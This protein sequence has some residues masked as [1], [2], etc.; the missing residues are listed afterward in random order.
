MWCWESK[1]GSHDAWKNA[2]M[3]PSL[4]I[5]RYPATT[6][7]AMTTMTWLVL[8][9]LLVCIIVYVKVYYYFVT[10]C[11]QDGSN[12]WHPVRVVAVGERT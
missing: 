5:K 3:Q 4:G 2:S 6:R 10:T 12:I 9:S 7:H 11:E 1:C 8:P